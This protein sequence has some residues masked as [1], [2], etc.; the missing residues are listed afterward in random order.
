MAIA[1]ETGA[2][3]PMIR[4]PAA[5]EYEQYYAFLGVQPGAGDTAI[6]TAYRAKALQ[7]HPDKNRD[8][9]R[10]EERF[11][12]LLLAYQR[13]MDPEARAAYEA[14]LR[15][16]QEQAERRARMDVTRRSLQDDLLE[17]EGAAGR[18][19]REREA[20][21]A[22]LLQRLER[23]KQQARQAQKA[24][25]RTFSGDEGAERTLVFT[26]TRAT[27][28][29]ELEA[30]LGVYDPDVLVTLDTGAAGTALFAS[31][32]LAETVLM[33]GTSGQL[34][35]HLRLAWLARRPAPPPADTRP[36]PGAGERTAMPKGAAT[37][38]YEQSTLERL[39]QL[40][41]AK[42]RAPAQNNSTEANF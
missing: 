36:L 23:L 33:L 37:R 2:A 24:Q 5:L 39:R 32:L 25:Q 4:P 40:Q 9:P 30:L 10:A 22:Q 12:E 20:A 6:T 28:Q 27:S 14:L 29:S 18:E 3:A 34:P 21:E 41:R 19:Q 35:A 42:Q 26:S 15:A 7:L 31:S 38:E 17:R 16:R 11:H 13:L 1:S 8:D